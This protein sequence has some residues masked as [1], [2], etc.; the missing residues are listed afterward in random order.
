MQRLVELRLAEHAKAHESKRRLARI[1]Q[2][3]K[4]SWEAMFGAKSFSSAYSA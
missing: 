2:L 3:P 1:E 4:P